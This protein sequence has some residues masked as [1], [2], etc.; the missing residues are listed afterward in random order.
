MCEYNNIYKGKLTLEM[1]KGST[2]TDSP[3]KLKKYLN[4]PYCVT[5]ISQK[6]Y[7]NVKVS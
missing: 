6:S 7:I 2:Y 4:K 1:G 3:P 5:S